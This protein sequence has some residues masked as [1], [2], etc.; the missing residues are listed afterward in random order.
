MR[1]L[2]LGSLLALAALLPAAGAVA[3]PY[4]HD[5]PWL[6][7]RGPAYGY[8]QYYRL[9]QPDAYARRVDWRQY[10]GQPWRPNQGRTVR[11]F[12]RDGDRYRVVRSY[13]RA[14]DNG[15]L[16]RRV[17]RNGEPVTAVRRVWRDGERSRVVRR[18]YQGGELARVVRRTF[19][20]GDPVRTVTKIYRDGEPVRVKRIRHGGRDDGRAQRRREREQRRDHEPRF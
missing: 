1:K 2:I 11:R 13:R 19:R 7:P 3:D 10:R 12:R 6:Q 4:H 18:S 14:G 9:R 5:R 17:Y 16:V 20:D 15:R 8:H